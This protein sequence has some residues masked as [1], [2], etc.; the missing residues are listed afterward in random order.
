[1]RAQ[2]AADEA[3]LDTGPGGGPPAGLDAE[4]L[5][6]RRLGPSGA[7]V[8][9][10]RAAMRARRLQR[11]RTAACRRHSEFAAA[12]TELAPPVR[13]VR[14]NRLPLTPTGEQPN[15]P[16]AAGE[17]SPGA[18]TGPQ[19]EL[20]NSPGEPISVNLKDVDLRDFFRLIH[21]ISGLN[22]VVDPSVKGTSDDRAGRCAVGPGA[23]YRA[24]QQ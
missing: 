20:P 7:S 24:A 4:L 17:A 19:R 8:A 1:M 15:R 11:R 21:E 13:P 12:A 5:G 3:G 14:A 23:R 9:P 2:S 22:V 18:G 10:T 6:S 16:R